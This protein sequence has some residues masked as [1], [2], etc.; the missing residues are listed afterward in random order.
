V[1]YER[2]S[3]C[4]FSGALAQFPCALAIDGTGHDNGSDAAKHSVRSVSRQCALVMMMMRRAGVV[5]FI[6]ISR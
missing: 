5:T 1:P 4:D 2:D 6:F 3:N